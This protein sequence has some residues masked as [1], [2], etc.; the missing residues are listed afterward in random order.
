[1]WRVL[2]LFAGHD[3]AAFSLAD[4]QTKFAARLR[5]LVGDRDDYMEP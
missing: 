2:M 4:A 5:D 1:M 3:E